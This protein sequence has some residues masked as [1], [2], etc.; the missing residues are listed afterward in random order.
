MIYSYNL[1]RYIGPTEL[2]LLM[3]GEIVRI[4]RK[5]KTFAS[6]FL[7]ERCSNMAL[8][9]S[10]GA[11]EILVDNETDLWDGAMD[12]FEAFAAYAMVH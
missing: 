4:I 11:D 8:L 10:R 3:P 12:G 1:G 9:M 7:R 5:G 2:H 6:K